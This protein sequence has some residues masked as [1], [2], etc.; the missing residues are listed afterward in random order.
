MA[1]RQKRGFTLIELSIA[2]FIVAL[3]MVLALPSYQ[4]QL[5]NTRRSLGGAH[6][7]QVMLRQQ[8]YF[9]DHK[10]FAQ[11][12]TD[13]G[14][15]TSPYAIDAAGN[16][17]SVS[18]GDRV[19]LIELSLREDAYTLYATPQ[20]SQTKDNLCGVLSLDF[21]GAKRVS[22]AGDARYCW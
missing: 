17:V 13:L 2:V 12:L 22:G 11:T 15:P 10:Q 21:T 16:P 1:E 18:A 14:Y 20:R 3:L 4:R 7:M 9:L 8:Q 6:L 5:M 19:Y